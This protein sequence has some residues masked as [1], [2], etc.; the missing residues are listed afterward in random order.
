MDNVTVI[1]HY[2][3]CKHKIE[4]MKLYLFENFNKLTVID[5]YSHY[6]EIPNLDKLHIV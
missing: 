3:S 1:L 6:S 2:F 5:N 4:S